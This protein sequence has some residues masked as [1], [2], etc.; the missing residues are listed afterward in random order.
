M[1]RIRTAVAAECKLLYFAVLRVR[2][3]MEVVY[4]DTALGT[5]ERETITIG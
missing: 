3:V 4:S 5:A 1:V 2:W